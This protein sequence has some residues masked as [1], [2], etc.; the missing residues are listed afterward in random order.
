MNKLSKSLV[1]AGLGALI[2][3]GCIVTGTFVITKKVDDFT[4][5]TSGLFD[6]AFVDVT[7]E[8]I[9]QD[10]KDDIKYISDV[11]FRG[12]IRN[13]SSNLAAGQIYFS[14]TGTYTTPAEVREA[15]D[16]GDAFVVFSGFTIQPQGQYFLSFAESS[17]YRQNLDEA[18]KL[19]ES[20]QFYMYALTPED[21]F[22]LQVTK[23]YVMLVLDAGK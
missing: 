9:W 14:Y 22:S 6:A 19:L 7:Q 11:R 10:H 1:L 15:S 21:V 2:L 23:A 5:S 13:T 17:Q 20:G 8:E 3:A 16:A 12:T 18:L 4:A